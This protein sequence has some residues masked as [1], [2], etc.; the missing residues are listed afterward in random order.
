MKRKLRK[1]PYLIVLI[2]IS[3]AACIVLYFL[4]DKVWNGSFVD[5]FEWNFM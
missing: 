5:W 3:I 2:L 1:I 4:V